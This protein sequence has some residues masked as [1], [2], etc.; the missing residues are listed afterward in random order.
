MTRLDRRTV[1][2]AVGTGVATSLAGCSHITGDD[3]TELETDGIES[4]LAGSPPDYARPAPVRPSQSAIQ[5]GLG[6]TDELLAAVPADLSAEDVP[7]GAIRSRI[8]DMRDDAVGQREHAEGADSPYRKL[9][10]TRHARRDAAEPA[11]AYRAVQGEVTLDGLRATRD[12]LAEKV[13]A[14]LDAIEYVGSDPDRT[15]YLAAIRESDLLAAGRWL[16]HHV[17]AVDP[18]VL[19]IGEVGSWVEYARAT[20]SVVDH[21]GARHRDQVTDERSFAEDF[22]Q[23]LDRT[24]QTIADRQV[25]ERGDQPADLVESDVAGTATE[26]VLDIC[27]RQLIDTEAELR[28]DRSAGHLG[29][30]LR[31]AYAA[32]RDRRAYETVRERIADGDF[33]SL[34]S[35]TAI[36]DARE[37]AIRLATDAS[38]DPGEPSIPA[39][40]LAGRVEQIRD[41]DRWI[42]REL[43][44][45]DTVYAET[46]ESEFARYVWVAEQIAAL[47]DAADAMAARL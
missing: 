39:E 1:L 26:R 31:G 24:V 4:A 3:R 25:P 41:T 27:I 22:E 18:S 44:T 47:P 12:V 10:E 6:R 38:I 28:H 45:R 35:T 36:R 29:V 20:R 42:R 2:A 14:D 13:A 17:R 46:F 33:R 9:Q 11:V 37:R 21:L 19:D 15:L 16:D 23:A 8:A 34:D 32:E 5:A 7:N 30:G 40:M 43:E